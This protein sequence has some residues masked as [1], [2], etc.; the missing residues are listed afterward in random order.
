MSVCVA[1]TPA[2]SATPRTAEA[3]G[4]LK[5]TLRVFGG[6]ASKMSDGGTPPPR[7][8]GDICSACP[9]S[10]TCFQAETAPPRG[11]RQG[12]VISR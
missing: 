7:G 8:Y 3:Q 9:S 12:R 6:P 11:A 4:L 1:F 10:Q 5:W 2:S